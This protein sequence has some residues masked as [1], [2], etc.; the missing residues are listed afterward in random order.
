MTDVMKEKLKKHFAANA[1]GLIGVFA[2]WIAIYNLKMSIVDQLDQAAKNSPV[3]GYLQDGT[4]SQE[5]FVAHG[6]KLV[7]RLGFS[8]INLAAK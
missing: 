4:E 6:L 8:R 7:N 5:G 2:V 3:K 1:Q